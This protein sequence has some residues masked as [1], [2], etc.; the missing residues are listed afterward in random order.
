MQEEIKQRVLETVQ[1]LKQVN[2][3]DLMAAAYAAGM[4]VFTQYDTVLTETGEPVSV[5]DALKFIAKV[6]QE[7]KEEQKDKSELN[8]VES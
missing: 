3:I 2:D 6:I 5:R 4:T 8:T 7:W 1:Q